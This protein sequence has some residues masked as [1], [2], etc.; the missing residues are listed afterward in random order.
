M[1]RGQRRKLLYYL[2]LLSAAVYL[3]TG[4]YVWE[5]V[6][7][8]LCILYSELGDMLLQRTKTLA[9]SKNALSPSVWN[10]SPS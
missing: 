3:I 4:N 9:G 8:I 7:V 2:A 6:S 1:D 10:P 5:A